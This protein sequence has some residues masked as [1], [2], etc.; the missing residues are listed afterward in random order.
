[1]PI[2]KEQK[3]S[4]NPLWQL[5]ISVKF[6]VLVLILL[7]MTS[8]AGTIIPQNGDPQQY[9]QMYGAFGASMIKV[10]DLFDMYHSWWFRSLIGVL[11][12]NIIICT[13]DRWPATWKI[14]TSNSINPEQLLSRTHQKE[15]NDQRIFDEL[16]PLYTSFMKKKY[17]IK[18]VHTLQ[19]GF[20]IYGEK[21]RWS[22]IGVP[23]V[24]LSVVLI[25]MGSLVGSFWGF[26]GY[27]NVPEGGSIDRIRL[28]N[29]NEIKELGFEVVCK[30]FNI[31]YYDSGSVK[32]YRSAL[33]I[34][35]NDK[36][37]L[38]R[39]IIVND[40][41]TY[42]GIRFFQSSYDS[43]P[44]ENLELKITS[45]ESGESIKY[46]T[47]IGET[48][49]L[50]GNA[51]EFFVAEF[52]KDFHFKDVELGQ[53]IEGELKLTGKEPVKIVLPFK[54]PSFDKMRKDQWIVTLEG[55]DNKYYTGLQ[56]S[57]DPGVPLVYLGFILMIAGCWVIFFSSHQKI[58]LE[59]EAYAE[60]S[61]VKI[62]GSAT[63]NKM[64][65]KRRI[66]NIAESLTQL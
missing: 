21:G 43:L 60:T 4:K 19:D 22:K 15:F 16:K 64:D 26:D 7:A 34:K 61:R 29:S 53:A 50:P 35:E 54:F 48:V 27:V 37:V 38:E 59:V 12:A 33:Q 30:D 32:E 28:R 13:I 39:D 65:F 20:R 10:L 57:R 41:L 36:V 23:I 55:H 46:K 42:K 1:M 58:L 62:F 24:H 49:Q 56:V 31:S 45:K 11:T 66:E 3:P 63:R 9:L 6:T 40:P 44:P 25:L 5:F 52:N 2:Q 8:A 14:V 51:G 47:K 18:G 17:K